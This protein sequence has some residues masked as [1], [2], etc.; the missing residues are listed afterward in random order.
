MNTMEAFMM[1]EENQGNESRIFDWE[2]AASLIRKHKPRIAEAGLDED[3]SYTSGVIWE[4][5]KP[6]RDENCYLKSVWATPVL[7]LDAAKIPCWRMA[8]QAPGWAACTLWPDSALNI[9][10]DGDEK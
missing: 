2:R 4:D 1:A 3:W 5:E 10:K 9:L 6:I 8:P 7:Y